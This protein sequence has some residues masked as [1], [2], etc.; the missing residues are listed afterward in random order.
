MWRAIIVTL[1]HRL[2]LPKYFATLAASKD[3]GPCTQRPSYTLVYFWM[4]TPRARPMFL[5][6]NVPSHDTSSALAVWGPGLGFLIVHEAARAVTL[7]GSAASLVRGRHVE[8]HRTF[9]NDHR[10]RQPTA[11][12]DAL[13]T[14]PSRFVPRPTTLTARSGLPSPSA[15]FTPLAI[16]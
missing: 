3:G 6:L 2:S 9:Y 13:R 16:P 7:N 4:I 11:T 14:F 1:Y 15:R 10:P 8:F 5:S 12:W